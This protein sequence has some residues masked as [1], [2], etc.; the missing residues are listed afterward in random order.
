MKVEGGVDKMENQLKEHT[1]VICA[2]KE[3]EYLEECMKNQDSAG[4]VIECRI[5][6]P[7]AGLGEPVFDKLSALLAHA[8]MS[9]GA[10]KAVEIGDGI[11]VTSSNGS[12]D[13]D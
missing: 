4:G 8:L 7:P 13:N 9:I 2:Y 5:T 11:A 12:T 6:G 10:V 3:S 1:F